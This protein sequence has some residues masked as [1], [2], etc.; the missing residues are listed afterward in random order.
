MG[1][2]HAGEPWIGLDSHDVL[3]DVAAE[4]VNVNVADGIWDDA[5]CAIPVD[6]DSSPGSVEDEGLGGR[7]A[8]GSSVVLPMHKRHERA[9]NAG[10]VSLGP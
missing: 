5:G 10:R 6:M 2:S 7:D 9:E 3:A 1:H 4:V 8:H